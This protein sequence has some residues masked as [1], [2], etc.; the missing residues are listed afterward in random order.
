LIDHK[1][2]TEVLSELLPEKA[3]LIVSDNTA[4]Y[5][6][7][8]DW[9]IDSDPR[10]PHK[11]S[12]TVVLKIHENAVRDLLKVGNKLEAKTLIDLETF[13]KNQLNQFNP[14]HNRPRGKPEPIVKWEV[15]SLHFLGTVKPIDGVKRRM[16]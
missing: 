8:F 4:D 13:F 1:T 12:K 6:A 9:P 2:I 11:R 14:N 7:H 15:S 3:E 16:F 10:R 5:L